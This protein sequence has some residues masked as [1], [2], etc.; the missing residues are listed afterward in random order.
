MSV[1]IEKKSLEAHVELCAERYKA[2]DERFSN[3]GDRIDALDKK[4][5]EKIGSVSRMLEKIDN[6][7]TGANSSRDNRLIGWGVSVIGLL[8]TALA[9][10]VWHVIS[11]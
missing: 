1:D 11:K 4:L 2:L 8:V 5:E 3:L 9:G 7:L 10:L 6:D